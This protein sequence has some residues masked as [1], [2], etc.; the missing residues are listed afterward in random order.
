MGRIDI[1]KKNPALLLL[2]DDYS[3]IIPMDACVL[4]PPDRSRESNGVRPIDFM[5]YSKY[6]LET[7]FNTFPHL[8]IHEA[9]LQECFSPSALHQYLTTRIENST[10]ILL[11]D[12]DL[13]PMEE[14]YRKTIE[15]DIAYYTAYKLNRITKMTGERS[16]L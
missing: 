5:F 9:V 4:I 10:L 13:T 14:V 1:E 2:I 7:L 16:K 3:Q 8:A 15:K 11:R 6:W 12:S